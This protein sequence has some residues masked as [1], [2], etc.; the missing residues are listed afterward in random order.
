VGGL[1]REFFLRAEEAEEQLGSNGAVPFQFTVTA[2]SP[3]LKEVQ[4]KP[5][6]VLELSP[7]SDEK[8]LFKREL[9]L[10]LSSFA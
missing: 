4:N 1:Y 6:V 2:V 8:L 7:S 9:V 10:E 5:Y 3:P